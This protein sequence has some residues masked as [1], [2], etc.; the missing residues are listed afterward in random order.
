M[1]LSFDDSDSRD[2]D[3]VPLEE[4]LNYVLPEELA[5]F[6]TTEFLRE[7]AEEVEAERIAA[8]RKPI[9][10]PVG[11][12]ADMGLSYAQFVARNGVMPDFQQR[13]NPVKVRPAADA[14][15]SKRGRPSRRGGPSFN[16]P[17]PL[18]SR[19]TDEESSSKELS[20][21]ISKPKVRRGRPRIYSMVAA[22]GI[23][24]ETSPSTEF[25]PDRTPS[26][27]ASVQIDAGGPPS[28]KRRIVF[29]KSPSPE[30]QLSS[31]I[32]APVYSDNDRFGT[33]VQ[34]KVVIPYRANHVEEPENG[35]GN[36]E[37]P[38]KR[39]C[40]RCIRQRQRCEDGRPCQRCHRAGI[41]ADGCIFEA[42]V[43]VSHQ[44]NGSTVT[45]TS[46]ITLSSG[47]VN[48]R[49]DDATLLKPFNPLDL[50]DQNGLFPHASRAPS[51]SVF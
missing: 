41:G 30:L 45:T 9:G 42:D 2:K 32:N 13:E 5:R 26:P 7:D 21:A 35:S 10:R 6:E 3:E 46:L 8:L 27:L 38:R 12:R 37:P 24:A 20:R 14:R 34:P 39:R 1:A 40:Q 43:K 18:K 4:I 22:A 17:K 36:F 44:T 11:W 15:Q 19:S 50:P 48:V 47:P 25:S 16:G 29:G 51:S 28:R 23:N 31:S 33:D 49:E